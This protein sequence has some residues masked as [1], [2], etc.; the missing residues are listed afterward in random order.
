VKVKPMCFAWTSAV[1]GGRVHVH[2]RGRIFL[3]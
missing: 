2:V 1:N 3:V